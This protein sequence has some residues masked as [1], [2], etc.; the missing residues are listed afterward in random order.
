MNK[1]INDIERNNQTF[2]DGKT[3]IIHNTGNDLILSGFGETE[4]IGRK[5]LEKKATVTFNN[6]ERKDTYITFLF[7]TYTLLTVD[8]F[9]EITI[10]ANEKQVDFLHINHDDKSCK[11]TFFISENYIDKNGQLTIEFLITREYSK[12]EK[13]FFAGVFLSNTLAYTIAK[14]S[15]PI[16]ISAYTQSGG[17]IVWDFLTEFDNIYVER[18]AEL[19]FLVGL[20]NLYHELKKQDSLNLSYSLKVFINHMY[21]YYDRAHWVHGHE[22]SAFYNK[23]FFQNINKFILELINCPDSFKETIDCS[24]YRLPINYADEYKN[25]P[26]CNGNG[27]IFYHIKP[28]ICKDFLSLASKYISPLLNP[29]SGKEF[30]TFFHLDARVPQE[31]ADLMCGSDIKFLCVYRDPRDQY[32]S[33]I[34]IMNKYNMPI[35]KDFSTP[36]SFIKFYSESMEKLLTK[37]SPNRLAVRFE[38]FVLE[39]D[40]TA[41]KIM[42]FIGTD[43]IHHKYRKIYFNPK[44][45]IKNIGIWRDFE[46]QEAIATIEKILKKYCFYG[47]KE[48]DNKSTNYG[49]I[50]LAKS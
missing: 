21:G 30:T 47:D 45:S 14:K 27:E 39:Y 35:H 26:F 29:V 43:A 33:H 12:S 19:R 31:E 16:G 5:L 1:K 28:A 4:L 38:D 22:V 9:K 11:K 6:L 32:A 40:E 50:R 7:Y 17:G 10:S 25:T 44:Y 15:K 24:T 13:I 42:K 48:N 34:N 8:S 36:Q 46:D 3:F 41:D 20:S 18:N 23:D 37:A 2:E 49:E